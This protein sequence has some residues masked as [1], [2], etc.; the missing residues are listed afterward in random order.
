[1]EVPL[2][3]NDFLRRAA[4][5]YPEKT[6]VID[7]AHRFTYRELQARAR[8]LANALLA[9][10]VQKGDRVCI[11]SPNSHFFLESFFGTGLIGAILVPLNYRLLAADHEYILNH[12]GVTVMMVDAEYAAIVDGIR[13]NL[14]TVRH[15]IA[16]SY[17]GR[18]PNGWI[19][20]DA[21]VGAAPADPPPPVTLEENDVV[22]LNYT[23][24]TT[25]RPKGAMLT[26]RNYY[27]NAYNRLPTSGCA[28]RTSSCGRCR[29]STATGGAASTRSLP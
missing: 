25:A 10:G 5:L 3:I 15:W 6:A 8:R 23:S 12:A 9:L 17:D 2:L 18:V 13:P 1:M 21:W 11:L 28:T 26:H 7:G 24:G 27:V 22:S 4:K 19:D 20:W 14:R 16:A 29:C